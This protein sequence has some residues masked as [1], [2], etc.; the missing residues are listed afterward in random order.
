MSNLFQDIITTEEGQNLQSGTSHLEGTYNTFT[1]LG[2]G[3]KD[4][5]IL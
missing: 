1:Y 2:K 4:I 3:L 5:E